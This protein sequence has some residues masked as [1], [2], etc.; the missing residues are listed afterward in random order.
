VLL[1]IYAWNSQALQGAVVAML[2]HGLSTGALF[3]LAGALQERLH[4][5]DMRRMGGL[6][7][8]MPKL[9]GFSLFFAMASL[10]LPGL[11]NFIGEFLILLGAYRANV[12]LAILATIGLVGAALYSL[13]LIQRTF[14]G[15]NTESWQAPDL[16]HAQITTLGVMIILTIWIG[17]YPQPILSTAQPALTALQAI[18]ADHMQ[19]ARQELKAEH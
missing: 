11:A 18:T 19:S 7:S 1:G 17:L 12:P 4:T 14:H 6:W 8:V 15:R 2:A 10:G 9:A 16:S 3:I 13:I 5:R